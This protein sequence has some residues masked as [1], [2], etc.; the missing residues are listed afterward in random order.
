MTD[1]AYQPKSGGRL[2]SDVNETARVEAFSDGV[3]AIAVTL[4]VLQLKVPVLPAKPT[5]PMLAAALAEEWPSYFAFATSFVTVLIMWV[6]HHAIFRLIRQVDAGLMFA[7][8]FVLFLVT[9]VPFPTAVVAAYIVSPAASA[10]AA[11]YAGFFV[12]INVAYNLLLG[13]AARRSLAA[14]GSPAGAELAAL[15]FRYRLG[16][17]FYVLATLLAPVSPWGSMAL[18][19]GLWAFWPVSTVSHGWRAA[20]HW[21]AKRKKR[22]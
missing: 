20:A 15:R 2:P 22:T 17:P 14:D 18:C 11:A 4:L 3:F 21:R 6:N 12:I 1:P 7:N 13:A 16:F 5:P 8:G 10:A 9:A 19:G